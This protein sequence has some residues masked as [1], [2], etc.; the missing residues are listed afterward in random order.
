[1]APLELKVVLLGFLSLGDQ[2]G[3][4]LRHAMARSVGF[5]F[6]ACYGSIYPALR[7]LQ[8]EGLVTVAEVV[9]SGRPNK[10]VYSLT[11]AG[12][13][14]LQRALQAPPG[15]ESF[16]SDFLVHLFFG[17]LLGR[18]AV[19]ELMQQ[20][21]ALRQ[22]QL[23]RLKAMESTVRGQGT[24]YQQLAWEFGVAYYEN[25]LA[26]LAQAE[27]RV[28]AAK[29]PMR[30]Q[31]GLDGAGE[32]EAS[33]ARAAGESPEVVPVLPSKSSPLPRIELLRKVNRRTARR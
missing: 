30:A 23:D 29:A 18:E 12:R 32:Q 17:H 28:R 1:M 21:R 6:G 22:A 7:A 33:E 9:Q 2:T 13:A 4:E 15:K 24:L 5:F 16:R 27:A 26:W 11:A 19:L 25:T 31:V 10:K 8:R 20:D 14:H 3:Y